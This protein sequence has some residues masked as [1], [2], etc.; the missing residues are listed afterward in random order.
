MPCPTS[1]TLPGP[2][3]WNSGD[4]VFLIVSLGPWAFSKTDAHFAA[5]LASATVT[6]SALA[7]FA[8]SATPSARVPKPRGKKCAGEHHVAT[9]HAPPFPGLQLDLP[10][11]L[12]GSIAQNEQV[13]SALP[14]LVR[15]S[16]GVGD[17][18]VTTAAAGAQE[19]GFARC[20]ID[21]AA[22]KGVQAQS[23]D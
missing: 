13:L 9:L 15:L 2:Q 18:L 8:Y 7:F 14:K 3:A 17:V 6:T 5:A 12:D 23:C 21:V 10:A 1:L 4:G 11:T 20:A 16:S 19:F 22:S